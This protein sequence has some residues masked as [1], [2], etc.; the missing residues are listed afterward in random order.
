MATRTLQFYGVGYSATP[1]SINA[2][3]NGTSVFS[4]PITTL[5]T[6]LV[7]GNNA[8]GLAAHTALFTAD[9]DLGFTGNVPVSIQVT[10]VNGQ[11]VFGDIKIN[12]TAILN[13]VYNTDQANVLANPDNTFANCLSTFE[14]VANPPLTSDQIATITAGTDTAAIK[15]ILAGANASPWIS[16]GSTFI[17]LSIGNFD[18][19]NSVTIDGNAP[20]VDRFPQDNGIWAYTVLTGSTIAFNVDI[21]TAGR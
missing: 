2:T 16:S 10:G 9:I 12:H 17:P 7:R 3:V 4:G 8:A 15:A 19:R 14:A 21:P 5:D 18:P 6:P 20:T 13:P 1:I 11:V